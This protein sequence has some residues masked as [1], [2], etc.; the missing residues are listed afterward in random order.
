MAASRSSPFADQPFLSAVENT[1]SAIEEWLKVRGIPDDVKVSFHTVSHVY[2]VLIALAAWEAPIKAM[3]LRLYRWCSNDDA[4]SPPVDKYKR[5]HSHE[6]IPTSCTVLLDS[7]AHTVRILSW[8]AC[9][10]RP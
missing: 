5:R 1:E 10:R 4:C 7:M 6:P 3:A 2:N 9:R 8:S